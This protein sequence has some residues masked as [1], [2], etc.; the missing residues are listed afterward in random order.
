MEAK[1]F[2]L[3][4]VDCPKMLQVYTEYAYHEVFCYALACEETPDKRA[5]DADKILMVL[6]SGADSAIQ[7]IKAAIEVGSQ[8]IHFGYGVKGLTS[9]EFHK[10]LRL[11]ADKGKYEKIPMAINRNRKALA[12]IH[13]DIVRSKYVLSFDGKPEEVIADLLGS[14]KY[15]LHILPEWKET[16]FQELV[17][18]GYL[19]K[20]DIYADKELFPNLEMYSIGLDEDQ[21]DEFISDLI[22]SGKIKFPQSESLEDEDSKP[23]EEITNLAEYIMEFSNDL[24]NKVTD[25]VKPDY[26]PLHDNELE[27]FNHYKRPLFPVQAHVSTAIAKRLASSSKAVILQGEMSTGKSACMTA[28]ADG[29]A[30]LKGKKGYFALL[31]CPPS[32]TAK[33]PKEIKMLIPDAEVIVVNQTEDLI[34]YHMAW[35]RNGRKKTKP[36]FFVIAFTTLRNDSAIRPAVEY[37]IV[38]TEKQ[39][40]EQLPYYR[41]G[42]YCPACGKP[43]QT[44]ESIQIEI[45]DNKEVEVHTTH[46][47]TPEEFGTTRRIHH[48]SAYPRNAFCYYCGESLW[49]RKVMRRYQNFAEWANKVEKPLTAAILANDRA[50]VARIQADQ[51]DYPTST[52]MPRRVAAIEY[53]RRKMKND[54]DICIVD[55]VHELK[56]GM[57]AQGHAL[58]SLAAVSKK[59]I[60]GTGTLFGGKAEDIYYLLWR[61]FPQDMVAAGYEYTEV[62][63][64]NEEFGNVEETIFE[65]KE[66]SSYS[67][68][69]SRG[70]KIQTRKKVLPGISSFIFGKFLLHNV[71]NMRLKDVWPDPVE[72]VDTPTIFVE[73][74]PELRKYYQQM[75]STFEQEISTREDGYKLYP[76]MIDYGIAYPDN[77]FTFPDARLAVNGERELIWEANH[78]DENITLP[79]EAKLQEIVKAELSEGRACIV[80]VRDTGSSV[81][82]RD[83]R[84]RLK[85]KLEEIGAKVCILDTTTTATNRRSEW[86]QKKILKE[87]YN[88]CIVSQELVKVGLDLL[89]TPTLIYYQFSWSL[90]TINQS[91]RR[92]WRIGQTQECRN[93][94]LAYSDCYQHYMAELIAKKNRATQAINGDISSDGLSAML[95]DEGDLQSMLIEAIKKGG[96]TLEGSAEEWISQ[97]S[98]RARELLENIGKAK[99]NASSKTEIIEEKAERSASNGSVPTLFDSLFSVADTPTNIITVAELKQRYEQKPTKKKKKKYVAEHQLAFDLFA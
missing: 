61:L 2:T 24:V 35:I 74:T 59:V 38:G 42:Y 63:R 62:S 81:P 8:G 18:L 85:Q 70:G 27:R 11:F 26:D 52:S 77:P 67:N 3:E 90:Y 51:P 16:V 93:Y 49:T 28:I 72:F 54:I 29:L 13:E 43:H 39:V 69:N 12:L 44:I 92:A 95:G 66:S 40:K 76:Q 68:T 20:H 41:N 22:K 64:F 55:E 88:V 6:I 32:L 4:T 48:N 57:T 82:Q 47:M 5:Y 91:A 34:R 31:I 1:K 37:K 83:I 33:W 10:E 60:A 75:I 97:T 46:N 14:D 21:A 23:I 73:M 36:V 98:D 19:V 87:G 15:G 78:I 50:E 17:R 89:C 99:T 80:Y 25:M 45:Q 96:M 56:G 58:G 86:L 30:Q 7:S 84:P 53:I 65:R 71:V 79:K 9:Y 94:Y